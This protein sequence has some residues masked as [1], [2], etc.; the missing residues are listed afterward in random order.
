MSNFNIFLSNLLISKEEKKDLIENLNLLLSTGTSAS[1]AFKSI[2]E[3]SETSAVKYLA[4][5]IIEDI[6]SG[7][8]LSQALEKSKIFPI[9][10][11]NLIKIG[12]STGTLDKTLALLAEEQSKSENFHSKIQSA[13]LYPGIVL[14]FGIIISILISWFMLPKLALIFTSMHLKLPLITKVILYFGTFLGKYGYFVVPLF[15]VFMGILTYILFVNERTKRYGQAIL[16]I[17]PGVGKLIKETEIA[18][19]GYLLGALLEVGV[20]ITEALKTIKEST[21][22]Y[23]YQIYYAYLANSILEGNSFET[24]FKLYKDNY[25]I[26]PTPVCTLIISGEKTGK[27]SAVLKTLGEKYSA[28]TEITAKNLSII[29]EPIFLI[30]VWFVVVGIALAV[31]LPIYSLIGGVANR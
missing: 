30:I 19:L 23:K 1:E 2:K 11:V 21:P 31:I 15:F 22:I 26:L 29:L 12:E 8:S 10:T 13:M 28:K 17:I 6:D 20:P 27:L 16:F 5:R 7:V 4:D 9:Y 14:S 24:S 18:R 25:S 3:N